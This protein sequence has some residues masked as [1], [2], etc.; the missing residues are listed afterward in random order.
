MD[1]LERAPGRDLVGP[2]LRLAQ[3]S[4]DGQVFHTD[5]LMDHLPDTPSRP[6]A[7]IAS[8]LIVPLSQRPRSFLFYFRPEAVRTLDW[9]GDPNKTYETGP[10]GDRLTPRKSF[11]IWKETVRDRSHPW[12]EADLSFAEYAHLG[13]R[14]AA[15][16]QRSPGGRTHPGGGAPAC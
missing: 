2:L 13:G 4:P 5:R 8:V 16:Q 12:S 7:Q 6:T 1:A 14:G 9:G 15:V 3:D 10:L 11:A